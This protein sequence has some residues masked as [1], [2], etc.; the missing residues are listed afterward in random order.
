MCYVDIIGSGDFSQPCL[1]CKSARALF[2]QFYVHINID[3][4]THSFMHLCG[5]EKTGTLLFNS[6]GTLTTTRKHLYYTWK[7]IVVKNKQC[8]L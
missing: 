2:F 8:L 6:C 3:L 7:K 1:Q 4:F 5:G